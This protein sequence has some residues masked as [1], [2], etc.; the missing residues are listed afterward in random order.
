MKKPKET[1]KETNVTLEFKNGE[2]YYMLFRDKVSYAKILKKVRAEKDNPDFQTA[3]IINIRYEIFEI[4][5]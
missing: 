4:Y 2:L 5:D 1:I 3:K